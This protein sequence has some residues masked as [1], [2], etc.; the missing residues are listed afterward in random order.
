MIHG[1]IRDSLDIRQMPLLVKALAVHPLKSSKRD[2][3]MRDAPVHFAGVTFHPGHWLAADSD[4]I[5][6]SQKPFT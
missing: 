5:V 4:G 6:L 3:G 2:P 1:C